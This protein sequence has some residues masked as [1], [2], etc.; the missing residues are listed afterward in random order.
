MV[1]RKHLD[2]DLSPSQVYAEL[3]EMLPFYGWPRWPPTEIP[4]LESEAWWKP[5]AEG[6]ETKYLPRGFH[7]PFAR[8]IELNGLPQAGKSKLRT[9]LFRALT[10]ELEKTNWGLQIWDEQFITTPEGVFEIKLPVSPP[11]GDHG[12]EEEIDFTPLEKDSWL[13]SLWLQMRKEEWWRERILNQIH[14][15]R[16]DQWELLIGYRGVVDAMIWTYTLAAHKQDPRFIIP[17]WYRED[18]KSRWSW[19][20]AGSQALAGNIDAVVLMGIS[21]EKARFRR[22]HADKKHEGWV[23]DSPVFG[24]LSA[25]YGYFIEKVHPKLYDLHGTGLLVLDGEAGVEHNTR[26]IVNYCR[27][28]V[29]FQSNNKQI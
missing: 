4:K 16:P 29:G 24:D 13:S 27:K 1:E 21:Q 3:A 6:K 7:L 12:L 18:F 19:V 15:A 23:T 2:N 17:D 22:S 9:E 10:P 14:S 26:V 8:I 11:L 5:K 28:I 20:L 25:W